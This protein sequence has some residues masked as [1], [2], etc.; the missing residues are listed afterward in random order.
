[1]TANQLNQV[2][3][4]KPMKGCFQSFGRIAQSGMLFPCFAGCAL[5]DASTSSSVSDSQCLHFNHSVAHGDCAG[6]TRQFE[7]EELARN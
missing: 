4:P 2:P 5:Y 3:V 6:A 1:M 7:V